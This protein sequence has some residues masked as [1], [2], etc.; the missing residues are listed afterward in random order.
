MPGDFH[1]RFADVLARLPPIVYLGSGSINA[2]FCLPRIEI[3]LH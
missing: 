1:L 2:S 3:K